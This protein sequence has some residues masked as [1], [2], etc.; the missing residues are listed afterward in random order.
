MSSELMFRQTDQY[1]KAKT[2][3]MSRQ[4]VVNRRW[5]KQ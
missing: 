4:H 2:G 5:D 3:K 1:N